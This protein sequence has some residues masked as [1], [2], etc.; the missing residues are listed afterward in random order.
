M[1]ILFIT[2]P[3]KMWLMFGDT[4]APYLGYAH[5]GAVLEQNGIDVEVLD[6]MA[7]R[8]TWEEMEREVAVRKPDI[9]GIGS[10]TAW[11]N[12]AVEAFR[13]IKR[14]SPNVVTV[15]GGLHFSF[16]PDIYAKDPDIDFIVIGEGEYTLLELVQELAKSVPKFEKVQGLAFQ[17]NGGFVQTPPR[18]LIANLDDLPFPA[19]HLC[20]LEKNQWINETY[21]GYTRVVTSRGCKGRCHFCSQWKLYGGTYRTLSGKRIVDELQRLYEDFQ[22]DTIEFGDDSFNAERQ[23]MEDFTRELLDRQLPI[24][25]FMEARADHILRD[26]DLLPLMV[27]SGLVG[28]LIGVETYSDA[29]LKRERK[30][31]SFEQMRQC[32]K[33]LKNYRVG[34]IATYMIGWPEDTRESIKE[35]ARF[36]DELDP[37][38]ISAHVLLPYPGSELWD[39]ARSKG[40]VEDFNF[41]HYNLTTPIMSTSSLKRQEISELLNWLNMDFYSKQDRIMRNLYFRDRFWSTIFRHI[42]SHADQLHSEVIEE[43]VVTTL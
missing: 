27:E 41:D 25:W 4:I 30:G 3:M 15:A 1:K 23:K 40:V 20:K 24:K 39:E 16:L 42:L 38:V 8:L 32:F 28:V 35:S 10:A 9:V 22:I 17:K 7:E 13:R 2:P 19:Y 12:A 11:A 21:K 14:V 31:I 18:A 36:L 5:M 34:T 29:I 26:K 43:E 6:C 37:D 33:L